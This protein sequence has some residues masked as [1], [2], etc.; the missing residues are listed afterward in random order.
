VDMPPGPGSAKPS[1]GKSSAGR[2][3]VGKSRASCRG[4]SIPTAEWQEREIERLA[5]R[6]LQAVAAALPGVAAAEDP[7]AVV[8]GCGDEDEGSGEAKGS[9]GGTT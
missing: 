4:L 5:L 2:S 6:R 8:A 9:V 1:V 3:R 7:A